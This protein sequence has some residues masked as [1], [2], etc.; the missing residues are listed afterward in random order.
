MAATPMPHTVDVNFRNE[1]ARF[2]AGSLIQC[3]NCGNCTA[4]C[5][6]SEGETPFPRKLIRYAQLGLKEKLVQSTEPWLCYACGECTATCPRDARPGETMA[7][8]R[9]YAIASFDPTGLAARMYKS[10]AAM[11]ATT[12]ALAALL[13]LLLVAMEPAQPL[14]GWIFG[15]VP[16]QVVHEVGMGVFALLALAVV[17][18]SAALIRKYRRSLEGVSPFRALPW[19]GRLRVLKELGREILTMKRHAQC[20]EDETPEP[21]YRTPRAIHYSVMA[22]FLGLFTASMLDFLF[23]YFLGWSWFPPARVLGTI[24][25]LVMLYGVG[26]SIY[27]RYHGRAT[28]LT[29]STLSDWWLLAFLLVLAVTG[30]W[31]ETAVSFGWRS[32]VNDAVL[33][34]HTVMAMELVL[35]VMV[36]KLAHVIYRPLSLGLHFARNQ[37]NLMQASRGSDE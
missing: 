19:P 4:V 24:S 37:Q 3:F 8:L 7:A 16:Y 28:D 20:D 10:T 15:L 36:T 5:K 1:L 11:I 25:G 30:F 35:L 31:L 29:G 22:G 14:H 32:G 18:G 6:L 21:W 34:V 17:A 23:I 33:L 12:L 2:G 27:R 13:A 26:V 9:R